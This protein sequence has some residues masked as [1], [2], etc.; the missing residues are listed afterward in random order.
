MKINFLSKPRRALCIILILCTTAFFI[1]RVW[2]KDNTENQNTVDESFAVTQRFYG[3][4]AAEMERIAAI[5]LEDALSGIRGLRRII[6]S[7]E[8]GR[9]R[10]ICFFEGKEQGRYEA[11][12]EAA[13]RVYESLPRSAQRPEIYSSGDSR[14]PVFTAALSAGGSGTILEKAVKPALEGLP[15]VGYA[16]I[17]GTGLK[18]IVITLK[19]EE[20]AARK[21]DASDIAVVLANNDILLP[22]G[23]V[24]NSG[25]NNQEISVMVDGR[26]GEGLREALIP[27]QNSSGGV[28]FVR[29]EDVEVISEQERDY[30]SRSRLDGKE[31]ILVAVMGSEEADLGKL[32]VRI[33]EELAKFPDLKFTILSD[34]GE[35]EQK[36]RS[37]ALGAAFQGA[38][39]V[40]FLCFLL[41]F[42][43]RNFSLVCSLTVPVTLFFTA[44]LL[45][46]FGFSL[47]KLVLAG[48]SA[49]VGAAVDTAIL[50][51]EYFRSCK[52]IEEGQRAMKALRFPLV[53]GAITTVIA[54]LPLMAQKGSGLRSVAWAIA[55]IN[56][57]AMIF[58]LTLLPPLF[59]WGCSKTICDHNK[60]ENEEDLIC[61][62]NKASLISL[63]ISSAIVFVT[64]RF[65]P[66]FRFCRR[67]LAALV[68]LVLKRPLL[69]TCCW[70]FISIV[71]IAALFFNGADVEQESSEDSV[72]VQIEFEGGLHIK[73]TDRSLAAYG[74]ELK[75]YP[76]ITSIQ[77]VART[78]TGSALVSFDPKLTNTIAVRELMRN[79]S[80]SGGFVYILE[81]SGN[82]RSW[83]IRIAG[84][85]E[86]HCRELAA[87]AAR[88]CSGIALVSET[89]LNFKE[90]SPRMNLIADRER[91]AQNSFSFGGI[92]QTVRRGIHGPVAYKRIDGNGE[93][94]VRILGGD[95]PINQE[96]ILQILVKGENTPLLLGSLVTG[97]SSIE[98]SSIQR[99]NRRRSASISIRTRVMDPRRVRDTVMAVLS[100]LELPP[101]Y[102]V[103]FDPEAL[104]AAE[105][106]SAQ[107][108][109]FVLALLFC[110]MI[111][112]S[113]KESFSYPLVLLAVVP[114]S[115]A[116]PAI[117]MVIRNYPL[118][119]VSAAAFVA[120]SGLAINAAAI[121]AD[122]LEDADCN[123]AAY[124]GIFRRRLPVLASTTLTTVAAALPF[125]FIKSNA[126]LVIKTLSLVSALGVAVS[127]FCAVTLIPALL[128]LFPGLL[129]KPPII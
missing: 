95:A 73:E 49:G 38:C 114:P 11:I 98:A 57:V 47:D 54:L 72:Y 2:G 78:G 64:V 56:I 106:V 85:E 80:V 70:L 67:K 62:H 93:T 14:I 96:E 4:D 41:C 102:T 76:G 48:L 8:N 51:A 118:N 37:S 117:C 5:P 108:F 75:K 123:T 128:K 33:K 43:K 126:A 115:L 107:G 32:S 46:L 29:L 21:I 97:E 79:T 52:T 1:I 119:A 90:G 58:A 10:V 9:T 101:G 104:K 82:E 18:E 28:N 27:V 26:Y 20:A 113:L 60:A 25:I 7:S 127:A 12:R 121:V 92:G 61:N 15:G 83:R 103:E 89:V 42:G 66:L 16:E 81:S 55:S 35:A 120:V 122:A 109:L 19:S 77:T 112:A 124:Y 50:S 88:R 69:I 40:A 125:L 31:T 65:S 45:I 23:S 30:E 63:I 100:Q 6:S 84:D 39:M 59:L 74:S 111:I 105:G 53:S 34:R 99:E 13:Q 87:E 44:A 3:V 22:G 71:G 17:S 116:V 36:A 110:Y 94:D 86:I 129:K 68:H 24:R 91:I